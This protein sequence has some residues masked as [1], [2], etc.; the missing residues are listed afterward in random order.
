MVHSLFAAAVQVD[1]RNQLVELELAPVPAVV[2]AV[3][4]VRHAALVHVREVAR[5]NRA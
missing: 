5:H 4:P 2:A 3:G 1:R